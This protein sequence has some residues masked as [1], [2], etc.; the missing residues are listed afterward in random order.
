[1][2]ASI[3]NEI[4]PLSDAKL[5][6]SDL[7][8]QRGYGVFDFFKVQDGHPYFLSDYLD[9]FYNSAAV[10][11]LAVPLVRE[12]LIKTIFHLIEKNQIPESGV[13]MILT[14]GY[15]L[16]GY[17]P[18]KPNLVLTQH[19][20]SLPG[21]EVIEQGIKVITYE[22]VRDIPEAKTINYTMGIWLIDKVNQQQAADVLYVKDGIVSEFPR[23]NFFIVGKDKM[24][25][26]PKSNIL[27]GVTRKNIL[28]IANLGLGAV[29][30]DITL[31]EVYEAQ[32]AF[33]TSTT[34]RII[35][36]TK[37]NNTLIG[38]GKPG[39]VS[40]TLLQNLVELE[41]YDLDQHGRSL[42]LNSF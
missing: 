26:T 14:G 3:N 19:K 10:M 27:K 9:R 30:K 8:V 18:G 7:S 29:E 1:M 20:L 36:I 40:L 21:P 39:V 31:E 11:R 33:I 38:T 34:K 12:D 35:P 24:I 42:Y 15:S 5:H 2:F 23:S 13:K 6:I 22:Y 25:M 4:I 41:K 17:T 28:E 16:D 32:E 37:V